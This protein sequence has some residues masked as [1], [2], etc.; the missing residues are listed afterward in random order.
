MGY[1]ACLYG[2]GVGMDAFLQSRTPENKETK[3][4]PERAIERRSE[5][6]RC[7]IQ[8]RYRHFQNLVNRLENSSI[9]Q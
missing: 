3:F 1:I 6:V 2:T 7:V 4:K 8:I 5:A 9:I